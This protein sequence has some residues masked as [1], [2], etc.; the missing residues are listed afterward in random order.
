MED[1]KTPQSTALLR[2][3]RETFYGSH[4]CRVTGPASLPP[5]AHEDVERMANTMSSTITFTNL[6]EPRGGPSK[7]VKIRVKPDVYEQIERR[8]TAAGYTA[9]SKFMLAAALDDAA[10]ASDDLARRIAACGELLYEIQELAQRHRSGV[11]RAEVQRL[12][13]AWEDLCRTSLIFR[14]M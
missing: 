11:T 9:I 13:E 2:E 5:G 7:T 14:D 3:P 8:A 1:P 6:E 10:T 12:V 4:I